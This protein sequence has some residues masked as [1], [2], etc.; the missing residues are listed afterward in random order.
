[1]YDRRGRFGTEKRSQGN[2]HGDSQSA[3]STKFIHFIIYHCGPDGGNVC[4]RVQYALSEKCTACRK[5][6][7]F[8]WPGREKR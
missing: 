8:L 2:D 3:Q 7:C 6:I 1:M 5:K 4:Y